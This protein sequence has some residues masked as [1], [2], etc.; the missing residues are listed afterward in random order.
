MQRQ[1]LLSRFGLVVL[2]R[3][4]TSTSAE[5]LIAQ[6]DALRKHGANIWIAPM[7]VQNDISSTLVRDL[8]RRG[9]SIRYLVPDGVHEY[10]AA[11]GLFQRT[12]PE[13]RSKL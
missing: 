6:C 2:D 11:R 3:Q 7:P 8:V 10:I 4:G 13:R 1:E 5:R 9:H 12:S